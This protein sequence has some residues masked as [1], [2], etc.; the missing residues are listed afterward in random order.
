MSVGSARSVV[1]LM[2]LRMFVCWFCGLAHGTPFTLAIKLTLTIP[3][4]YVFSLLSISMD[5]RKMK[6]SL[7]KVRRYQRGIIRICKS[8]NRH[9]NGQ[10][11]KYKQRST[12]HTSNTKYRVL[13]T[14]PNKN[15]GWTHVLRKGG[16]FLF[17]YFRG[18]AVNEMFV[19]FSCRHLLLFIPFVGHLIS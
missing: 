2:V 7:R 4:F 1:W 10:K 5:W 3:W 17:S 8:K 14:H 11:K 6:C 12:K 19:N 16:Q 18:L 9:H 15:G 13:N